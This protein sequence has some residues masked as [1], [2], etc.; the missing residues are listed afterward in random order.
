MTPHQERHHC[1]GLLV[2]V[3]AHHGVMECLDLG[4]RDADGID[5][6]RHEKA[7]HHETCCTPVAS[8]EKLLQGSEQEEGHGPLQRW[9]C[10][11]DSDTPTKDPMQSRCAR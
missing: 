2:E 7:V 10:F 3:E 6:V 1:G 9:T 4:C 8:E 5:T 11:Q